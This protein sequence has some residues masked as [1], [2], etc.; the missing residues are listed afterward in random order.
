MERVP[1]SYWAACRQN[2]NRTNSFFLKK[3]IKYQ[4]ILKEH[5]D[6]RAL[7]YVQLL[8]DSERLEHRDLEANLFATTSSRE[9]YLLTRLHNKNLKAA[10]AVTIFRI[11]Q[12]GGDRA[13]DVLTEYPQ[14]DLSEGTASILHEAINKIRERM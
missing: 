3:M 2:E 11:G 14:S 12:F 8:R 10:R 4:L 7:E 9:A 6:Q 1:E 5:S 13:L